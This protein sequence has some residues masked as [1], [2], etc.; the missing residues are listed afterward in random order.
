MPDGRAGTIAVVRAAARS[1]RTRSELPIR[2]GLGRPGGDA[3]GG[4][5]NDED[6]RFSDG[7][8]AVTAAFGDATR[9]QI[10]LHVREIGSAT[11]AE[12][13]R[14]FGLHPNVARHH[15]DKLATAGYLE[16]SLERP[17]AGAGRP[18]KRYRRS[19]RIAAVPAEQRPDELVVQL[20]GRALSLLPVAEAMKMAEEVGEHYGRTL[21][22]EMDPAGAR[23]S[24]G[25]AVLAV[26][27]ALTAHGFAAHS[28]TR[29]GPDVI[30]R[31]HCPF[32][33]AAIANPVFCAADRGMVK[34]LFAG[35]CGGTVPIRLLSR[36]L[37]DAACESVA[38]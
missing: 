36:A 11:T 13:A 27:D 33:S 30:V 28:E 16:V 1:P 29:E 7:V 17:P 21:A 19:E 4:S 32:G 8:A 20:L 3:A 5:G 2:S 37:G 15:L 12:V 34:G 31:D 38:G 9:R 14:R 25:A 22:A 26:V 10:Y 24:P 6:E 23:R 18:S 35:L